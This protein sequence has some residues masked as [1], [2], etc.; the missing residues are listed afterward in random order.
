M[1]SK[2]RI[3]GIS[4][5]FSSGKILLTFQIDNFNSEEVERLMSK[6]LR[7]RA[8]IWRENK[9]LT[10]NGYYWKLLELM[11]QELGSTKEEIHEEILRDY[12]TIDCDE[13]GTPI[14]IK[15]PRFQDPKRLPGHWKFM[16]E[17]KDGESNVFVQI[18]GV[19]DCNTKE[20]SVLLDGA[21]QEAKELG[22]ETLPP[23]EVER[24]KQLEIN[25]SKR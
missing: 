11:A 2:A 6:D 15:Q 3:S 7:L 17:S 18:K 12:G 16:Y 20:M 22:V 1:E 24:L 23:K 21:I 10:Q 5:D 25:N 8:V 13:N 19:S 4:R 14:T 9:T